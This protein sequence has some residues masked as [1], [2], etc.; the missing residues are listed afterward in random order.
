GTDPR[1]LS[2]WRPVLQGDGRPRRQVFPPGPGGPRSAPST[3]GRP[4]RASPRWPRLAHSRHHP[5]TSP[6]ARGGTGSRRRRSLC[7][8]WL[9][10]SFHTISALPPRAAWSRLASGRVRTH[11]DSLLHKT[12][13]D[14]LQESGVDSFQEEPTGPDAEGTVKKKKRRRSRRRRKG[15]SANAAPVANNEATVKQAEA[16][17]NGTVVPLPPKPR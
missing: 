10:R 5:P 13:T 17:E 1:P 14:E 11:E 7:T 16:P 15:G 2:G 6:S 12:N 4:L 9:S 8:P 3:R